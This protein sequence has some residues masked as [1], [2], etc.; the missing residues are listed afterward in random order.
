MNEPTI[1]RAR[2]IAGTEALRLVHQWGHLTGEAILRGYVAAFTLALAA[3]VG[4]NET[5]RYVDSVLP[6]PAPEKLRVVA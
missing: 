4:V 5:R 3:M 1:Q 6:R 2:D